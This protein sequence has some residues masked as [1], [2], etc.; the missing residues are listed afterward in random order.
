M[1]W[2]STRPRVPLAECCKPTGLS[3]QNGGVAGLHNN[4]MET[5]CTNDNI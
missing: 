2:E 3:N 5:L 4:N 1:K